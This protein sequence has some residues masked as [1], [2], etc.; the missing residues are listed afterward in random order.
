[1]TTTYDPF[2]DDVAPPSHVARALLSDLAEIESEITPLEAQ[3]KRAREALTVALERCDGRRIALEGYGT[4][5]LAEPAMVKQWNTERLRRL[6][7]WLRETE[8][9]EIA[10]MIEACREEAPRA[11]GLRVEKEPRN[12]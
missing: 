6:C 8:R 3:R 5:R 11:G 9:D 1:M 10:D 2:I 4:A 12:G 7:D